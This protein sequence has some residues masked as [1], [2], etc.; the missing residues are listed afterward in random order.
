M[1]AADS[2]NI[3][4]ALLYAEMLCIHCVSMCV[5]FLWVFIRELLKCNATTIDWRVARSDSGFSSFE[6]RL[7]W[8]NRIIFPFS[9]FVLCCTQIACAM[10]RQMCSP[11]LKKKKP[12]SI[13]FSDWPLH[14]HRSH[15]FEPV[16]SGRIF[17]FLNCCH[18]SIDCSC[19]I[20]RKNSVYSSIEGCVVY[21]PTHYV[22]VTPS[23]C[24]GFWHLWQCQMLLSSD[25]LLN[26]WVPL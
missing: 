15:L 5:F 10:L 3:P 16:Q 22:M 2:L 8:K 13:D 20:M 26:S 24:R 21:L 14:T 11:C 23:P 18:F 1:C 17:L 25:C 19:L 7:V 4:H 9:T 6:R 12:T